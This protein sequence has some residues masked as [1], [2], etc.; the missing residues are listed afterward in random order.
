[1]PFAFINGMTD[2]ANLIHTV[3]TYPMDENNENENVMNIATNQTT[4]A[5]IIPKVKY[6]EVHH[7]LSTIQ[8][9]NAPL[10]TTSSPP[11]P[12]N[13]GSSNAGNKKCNCRK[14][15]CLKL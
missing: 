13:G 1:M 7:P 4:N 10:T 14:S 2:T 8:P 15:R 11:P 6:R 12:S 5:P 3:N 9:V